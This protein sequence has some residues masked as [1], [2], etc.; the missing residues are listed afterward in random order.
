MFWS[1]PASRYSREMARP[2]RI[3]LPRPTA[4]AWGLGLL[5]LGLLGAAI[6]TGNNLLYLLFGLLTATLP[7]SMAG[8]LFNLLK[9]RV[10]LRL[11]PPAHAGAPFTLQIFLSNRRR[12]PAARSLQLEVV[13]ERGEF[14]PALVERVGAGETARVVL[15]AREETRGPLRVR[16]VRLRTAFPLGFLERRRFFPCPG[17][18]LILPSLAPVRL[19]A[20]QGESRPGDV[21]VPSRT[22]GS[23]YDGLRRG[24]D[25]DDVRRVDWKSTARRGVL[26]VRETAGEGRPVLELDVATHRVSPVR[27]RR[28]FEEEVS[29]IAA[30]AVQVLDR[31]GTVFLTVDG[32]GREAYGGRTGRAALLARLARLQPTDEAGRPL[33]ELPP[34]GRATGPAGVRRAPRRTPPGRAHSASALAALAV[35]TAA[36]FAYGGLGPV[37]FTGLAVSLLAVVWSRGRLSV[38][39]RLASRLWRAAGIVALLVFITDLVLFRHNPLSASLNLI[40]FI[41]LYKLFNAQSVRDD[42]QILLVS[43]LEMILAAA[44]TTGISFVLPLLLWLLAAAHAQVAW[45]A[46]P[47]TGRRVCRPA[48]F[49]V[50]GRRIRYG[51]AAVGHAGVLLATGVAVFLMV[52]HL[53]TGAFAPGALRQATRSGFSETTRLG[54][55]GRIKLDSSRVMEVSVGGAVPEGVDLRWRGVVLD[56]FDGLEWTNTRSELEWILTDVR[57]RFYPRHGEQ[58]EGVDRSR[59]LHQEIRLEPGRSRALFAA[60]AP[61]VLSSEDLLFLAED[62]AGSLRLPA[63]PGRRFSYAVESELPVRSAALLRAATGPDPPGTAALHLRLPELDGRVAELAREITADAPTRYDAAVALESWLATNLTYSLEVDDTGRADPLAAFLFEGMAAHCEYFATS[64]VIL[65]RSAGIPSRFAAGYLRGERNRFSRVYTVRQSDAHSWVEIH[66]PGHGWVPFDPT[67]PAGRG[68]WQDRGVWTLAGDLYATMA[69]WWDDY[70]IGIDLDDQARGFLRLRDSLAD[71][72]TGLE[73]AL[74]RIGVHRRALWVF[75][76]LPAVVL[77]LIGLAVGRRWIRWERRIKP[78]GSRP[79]PRFYRQLLGLLAHRGFLRR[80]GETPEEL[81]VRA[82]AA[83]PE[84]AARRVQDLTSLYYRLRFDWG[85]DEAGLEI[86]ARRLLRDLRHELRQASPRTAA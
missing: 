45:T 54:D 1:A 60:A 81:A 61:R 39:S 3:G 32:R 56:R 30:R 66:F 58:A 79:V 2:T 67:P 5:G 74:D 9:V 27:A 65:A 29:R 44:L 14:G 49:Q 25:E 85:S 63:V 22:A 24:R 34:P 84:R 18:L 46:I 10:A 77:V 57:G 59:V 75:L 4:T 20:T 52:P 42:R 72:L 53:G 16:G 21:P 55:I 83:L 6:N 19:E 38:S 71:S 64:M 78:F 13:T 48:L 33:P 23:E 31:G 8:S 51:A 37:V 82:G 69:R 73:Q 28:T 47:G 70:V 40:A 76:L 62:G 11:P 36:L 43:L 80:P 15:T 35:S 86:L 50:P 12:R 41:A 68:Q 26:L 7:V 17:E